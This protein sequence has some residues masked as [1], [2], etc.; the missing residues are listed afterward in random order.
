MEP[1]KKLIVRG[2]V[3]ESGDGVTTYYLAVSNRDSADV[4]EIELKE[5]DPLIELT[6]DDGTTWM[7]DATTIHEVF[8]EIDPAINSG[9]QRGGDFLEF[10]IPSSISAPS[11]ERGIIGKI[12]IK[13]LKVFVKKGIEQTIGELAEK[14]ED[15]QLINNIPDNSPILEKLKKEGAAIF[16]VNDK[17]EFEEFND[18]KATKPYFLFI[19]GTN[20]DTFGAF[21]DLQQTKIWKTL[22]KTYGKNVL[23]FQHRTLTESPLTNAVKLVEMLPNKAVLHIISHS[24]GGIVGDIINKYSTSKES[25]NG[26]DTK[27]EGAVGFNEKHISLLEEEG[28]EQKGIT[29]RAEDIK[30]IK[31]LN[32]HFKNNEVTVE[33][34]IRVASPS[35]GTKLASKRLDIVLNVFSNLFGG[36]FGI[37]FREL[38]SV[39]VQTKDN[40]DVLPGLEAQNPDSPFIKILNDPSDNQAIDGTPLAIVSGNGQVSLSGKGLLVILGKLFFWQRNDLVVN[41]DSMY[42]GV[43]R[44]GEIQYFFDEGNDVNHVKYFQN[45]QTVKAIKLAIDTKAGK[46]IPGFNSIKQYEVPASDRALLEHGELYPPNKKPSG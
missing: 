8:P 4:H 39:A 15:K 25:R 24:R 10:E 31:K 38:L 5:K 27:K 34:F 26:A 23:A 9:A 29:N 33:K 19:H 45:N 32:A 14:L 11:S 13:L 20:S 42:L 16:R 21:Q 46:P 22:H 28:D 37:I 12:A 35:A 40:V 41:T 3:E 44:K 30:N 2:T 17:F 18:K 36:T 43:K 7:V 6:L 1:L